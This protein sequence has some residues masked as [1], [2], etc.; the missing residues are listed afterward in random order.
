MLAAALRRHIDHRALQNLQQRLLH[1]LA[2]DVARDGGVVALAGDLVDLVD[3][4]DAALGLGH[5]VVGHL[6]QTR[7]DA[8]HVLA[9]VARLGEHRGVHDG[10]GH[11]QQPRDGTGHEG[12]ARAGGAHEHDVRLVD[13]GLLLARGA[14]QAFV[15][16]VHGN[17]QVA[18]GLVLADHVLI[19]ELLDLHRLEQV[20]ATQGRRFAAAVRTQVVLGDHAVGVLH[21]LVADVRPVGAREHHLDIGAALAAKRTAVAVALRR[22]V[23]FRMMGHLFVILLAIQ[24]SIRPHRTEEVFGRSPHAQCPLLVPSPAPH[25][26]CPLLVP[27]PAPHAQCPV[28]SPALR[29][30]QAQYRPRSRP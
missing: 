7:E 29:P 9:H 16:V 28:R 13:L 20:L 12:L 19:E 2:R 5:I 30:P 15:V 11:L 26:Q 6:Q 18:L 21:A 17:G 8:L 24:Y 3:E 25:A 10:E 4:D 14:E 23:V 27:S 1:A 22:I